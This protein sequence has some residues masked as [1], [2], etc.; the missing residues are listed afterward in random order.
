MGVFPEIEAFVA[1]H[2]ACGEMTSSVEPPTPSGYGLRLVCRCGATLERWVTPE[3]AED[4][5]LRSKLLAF[6]N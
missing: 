6:P 2:K 1:G 3:A 4:D 5:L